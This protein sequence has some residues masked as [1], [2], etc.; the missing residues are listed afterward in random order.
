MMGEKQAKPKTTVPISN[1]N[2][3]KPTLSMTGGFKQKAIISTMTEKEPQF[4][5]S[6]FKTQDDRSGI[7]KPAIDVVKEKG[8]ISKY[9]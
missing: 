4:N 2:Y 6:N 1:K 3:L 8:T 9:F 7:E 5:G